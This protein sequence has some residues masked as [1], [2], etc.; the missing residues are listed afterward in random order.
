[1]KMVLT[2][3]QLLR[4]EVRQQNVRMA[5]VE[6]EVKVVKKEVKRVI[7]TGRQET[8]D[9]INTIAGQISSQ[10]AAVFRSLQYGTNDFITFSK[11]LAVFIFHVTLTL[12]LFS[13]SLS[14]FISPT[15]L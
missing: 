13:L 5:G 6:K 15:F 7:E 14:L 10:F 9:V 12:S 4:A 2:E 3:L 1:M 11:L 8:G